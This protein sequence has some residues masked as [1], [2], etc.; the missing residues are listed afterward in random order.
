MHLY[1]NPT[2]IVGSV[3]KGIDGVVRSRGVRSSK[4]DVVE[5]VPGDESLMYQV[6]L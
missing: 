6:G 5:T 4:E 1:F 3:L 2:Q